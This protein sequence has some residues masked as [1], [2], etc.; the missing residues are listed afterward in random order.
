MVVQG[1]WVSWGR[2][3]GGTLVSLKAVFILSEG[4]TVVKMVIKTFIWDSVVQVGR[5]SQSA[6]TAANKEAAMP[7]ILGSLKI[8]TKICLGPRCLLG[9]KVE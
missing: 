2:R 1:W 8:Y 9:K 5:F 3:E 4:N 6:A 7:L